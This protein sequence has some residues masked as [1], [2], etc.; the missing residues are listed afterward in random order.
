MDTKLKPCPFCQCAVT[1]RLSPKGRW[2]VRC[3]DFD[4]DLFVRTLDFD[5]EADA[6]EAW[7]TRKRKALKGRGEGE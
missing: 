2:Y 5:D 6:I 3:V 7:N 4:C 1:V